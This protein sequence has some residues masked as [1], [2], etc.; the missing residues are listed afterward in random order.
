MRPN[1]SICESHNVSPPLAE[2]HKG[3]SGNDYWYY[4]NCKWTGIIISKIVH[5]RIYQHRQV[6][7][8]IRLKY[9]SFRILHHV[10]DEEYDINDVLN[11]VEAPTLKKAQELAE[12]Y[13]KEWLA[14]N[15][16]RAEPVIA[17]ILAGKK[18]G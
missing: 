1:S 14:V 4:I 11:I 15:P 18:G 2:W 10:K 17:S 13:Y 9:P 3:R 5:L 12:W 8:R 6:I 7:K 16:N